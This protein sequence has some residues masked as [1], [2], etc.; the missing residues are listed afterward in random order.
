M[1]KLNFNHDVIIYP[2]DKGFMMMEDLIMDKY[3]RL[4]RKEAIKWITARL[5][6]DGGYKDQLHEI[7]T[8]FHPMFYNGQQL[9]TT[10]NF[11][12]IK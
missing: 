9:F 11:K 12:Y 5:T 7:M 8:T 6:D 4:S 3:E 2:N 10:M 1:K